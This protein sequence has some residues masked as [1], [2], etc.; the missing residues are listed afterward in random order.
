MN[1]L[2]TLIASVRSGDTITLEQNK[3]YHVRQDDSF[4]LSGYFCTNSAKQDENPDGH[5]YTAIFLEDKKDIVIEGNG[6]MVL[7]HGKMTTMLFNRC[8]NII[9]NAHPLWMGDRMDL[10]KGADTLCWYFTSESA[11]DILD[12]IRK[13]EKGEKGEGRRM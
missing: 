3:T 13:Y 1:E 8:E 5:R 9:V 12:V 2:S 6:A 10:L 7:V 4:E 11:D